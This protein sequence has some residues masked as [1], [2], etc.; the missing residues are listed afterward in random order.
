MRVALVVFYDAV[1]TDV[2]IGHQGFVQIHHDT[3][4][5]YP[6]TC[7]FRERPSQ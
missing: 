3:L 7:P 1:R 5:R 4:V 2:R 6:S